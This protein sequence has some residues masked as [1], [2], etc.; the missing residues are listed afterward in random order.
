MLQIYKDLDLAI[1]EDV[2]VT[3]NSREI[4]VK[5]P[6]GELHKVSF[7]WRLCGGQPMVWSEPS[8]EE[9]VRQV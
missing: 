2:E 3:I 8:E 1:P 6:R 9:D 7:R 5:G 4:H